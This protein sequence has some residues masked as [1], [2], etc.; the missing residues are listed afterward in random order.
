MTATGNPLPQLPDDPMLTIQLK[1]SELAA[2]IGRL[3]PQDT[4]MGMRSRKVMLETFGDAARASDVA[5]KITNDLIR[6]HDRGL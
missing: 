5:D 3:V 1:R 4:W 2:L 6:I